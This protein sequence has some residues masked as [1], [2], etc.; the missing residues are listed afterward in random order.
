M[1][2]FLLK[3]YQLIPISKRRK[4]PGF[5][6]Y[7]LLNTFLDLISIIYLIPIILVLLDKNKLENLTKSHLQIALSDNL[8][9]ILLG[10][11]LMFYILKNSIQT[12][13]IGVQTK[14]IYSISDA[15]SKKLMS[16]FIFESYNIHTRA[17]K[18]IFFR[19]VFQL[20]MTFA[21]NILFSIYYLFSE[22]F[23]LLIISIISF[24]YNP[25]LTIISFVLLVVLAYLLLVF[26][27]NKVSDFSEKIVQLYQENVRNIMN[28]LHGFIDIKTTKSEEKFIK[29]FEDSNK[30][31]NDQLALLLAFKQSNVKYFEILFILGLSIGILFF[32]FSKDYSKDLIFLSFLAGASIKIIP[33]FNK[34][35]NAF[36]D[37]KTN[38]NT[39]EILSGYAE[40]TVKKKSVETYTNT[41][42][43]SNISFEYGKKEIVKDV[44][45]EINK[46]DFIS[47]SGNSGEGKTTL[48]H[49]I[50]GLLI[51]KKGTVMIDDLELSHNELLFDF[52]G[53]ASQQPFLFQ[54]SVLENMTMLHENVDYSHLDSIIEA[55]ELKE[56]I[57]SLPEGILTPLLLE[58]K[59]LSGGQKQRIALARVLYFKPKILLLD[60]ITNQLNP[61]LEEKIL[62]YL[63][64][65]T[66]EN[67][68]AIVAVSHGKKVGQ[69][70]NREYTLENG[71]LIANV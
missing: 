61:A 11:L 29:K 35:L 39:V 3:T 7:S 14:F 62:D 32:V 24:I 6:I 55:L 57:K 48:L 56:W 15:I 19:D 21:T 20:P 40:E 59:K 22:V 10:S 41:L 43:I 46:G 53:Y 50:A 25:F 66:V 67:Q 63:K 44:N 64:Q 17:D 70:A 45:L 68:L 52:V 58:S 37:I 54:G 26:Q 16:K 42:K 8:I 71:K 49:I 27:K 9:L 4:L 69:F 28:I 47:I 2:N 34:I 33:S 65:L 38:K 1:K 30:R 18:N 51:P 12:R 13:I 36:I 23:L 5:F 60:E 31:N